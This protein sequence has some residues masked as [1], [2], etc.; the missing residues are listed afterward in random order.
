[1]FPLNS[2]DMPKYNEYLETIK[3]SDA[4]CACEVEE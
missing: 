3:E 2:D 4:E 1:M